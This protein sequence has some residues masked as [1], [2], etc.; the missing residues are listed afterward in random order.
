M[1]TLTPQG[2]FV[3]WRQDVSK[4]A[5]MDKLLLWRVIYTP[6]VTLQSD[7]FCSGPWHPSKDYV[8]QCAAALSKTR[9]VGVQ[10]NRQAANG[11]CTWLG[12]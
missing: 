10:S 7:S 12:R 3:P 1:I 4:V 2:R 6:R 9:P 5:E 11:A 8:H